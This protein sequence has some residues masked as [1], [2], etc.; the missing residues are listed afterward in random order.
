M[1]GGPRDAAEPVARE[2]RWGQMWAHQALLLRVARR[3]GA[4]AEDAEDAVQEAMIRAAEHP[5]IAEDR[6]Q[7]WLIA[8]TIRLC[9][10]GHRRRARETNRWQRVSARALVAQPGQYPEDEVCERSEAVWVASLAAELLPPR[11]VQALRLAAA[12]CD[13]QQVASHLGVRYR[14]AESLLA[15]ARRTVRTAV[16]TGLGVLV[17]AW[18]THVPTAANPLPMAFASATAAT[19]MVVAL[20]PV[21]TPERPGGLPGPPPAVL[22]LVPTPTAE[23]ATVPGPSSG[24]PHRSTSPGPPVPAAPPPPPRADRP[25]HIAPIPDEAFDSLTTAE[26]PELPD[27]RPLVTPSAPLLG[28]SDPVT[29]Q[30]VPE[31]PGL[32]S[33]TGLVLPAVGLPTPEVGLPAPEL[34]LPELR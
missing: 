23:D 18:R 26:L 9:M 7:A 11:Q 13:V 6:L 4:D 14:A 31:L 34:G 20:P 30:P 2:A 25:P 15:R 33:E 8:V 5:E 17:W 28:R 27:I 22:P 1:D 32:E 12:G 29:P 19:M 21:P 16:A 10:D 3:Y 24:S